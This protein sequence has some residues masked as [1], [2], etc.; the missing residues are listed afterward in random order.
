MQ[1]PPQRRHA[2]GQLA[3]VLHSLSCSSSAQ[4]AEEGV[5]PHKPLGWGMV[6]SPSSCGLPITI[7][8]NTV[9]NTGPWKAFQPGAMCGGPAQN[10]RQKSIL[11]L[12]GDQPIVPNMYFELQV[13]KR[14]DTHIGVA[15]RDPCFRTPEVGD[16]TLSCLAGTN[17][18][19]FTTYNGKTYSS[20][21]RGRVEEGPKLAAV[22][23]G[24]LV[25]IVWLV[26]SVGS[27]LEFH[28]NGALAG[29]VPL[30]LD[31]ETSRYPVITLGGGGIVELLGSGTCE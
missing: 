3:R 7:D 5:P 20:D 6:V 21:P 27:H 24:S 11:T 16:V 30:A 22:A 13:H 19:V 15:T 9:T 17:A 10:C 8:G 23:N 18:C 2:A 1:Q 31:G 28:V 25:R 26:S 4:M 14:C 29:R 12:F